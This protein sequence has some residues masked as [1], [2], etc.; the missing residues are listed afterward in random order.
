MDLDMTINIIMSNLKC[1]RR[2]RNI[3]GYER[4]FTDRLQ[5][6]VLTLFHLFYS[7]F[8]FATIISDTKKGRHMFL[9]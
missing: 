1:W 2:N 6:K 5:T 8:F 9:K 4:Y 7:F 3:Y